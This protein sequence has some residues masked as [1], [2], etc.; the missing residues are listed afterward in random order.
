VTTSNYTIAQM[1]VDA[2]QWQAM[3]VNGIFWDDAGY[4]YDTIRSRQTTMILYARSLGLASFMNA[5]NP[6][7]VFSSTVDSAHNPTG[8]ASVM[9]ANDWFLLESFPYSAVPS[10]SINAGWVPRATLISRIQDAQNWRNS[11]GSKIAA[12]SIV[13]YST[14]TYIQQQYFRSMTQ[15]IGFVS[16]FDAYGDSAYGYSA[17]GANANKIF[18]GWWD[19][20]MGRYANQD[21]HQPLLQD[22]TTTFNRHDY[23]TIVTYVDGS[24][25][26]FTTA[27][28]NAFVNGTSIISLLAL[29][30]KNLASDPV[31]H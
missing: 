27:L 22:T 12:A 5:W 9:G 3:G 29:S 24:Q 19:M 7:D 14:L 25:W 18:K 2:Q 11:F 6:D 8:A 30:N 17:S 15:A 13:D 23:E 10:S 4:D 16:S 20:E 28:T 21:G 1:Q 26:S 31:Y